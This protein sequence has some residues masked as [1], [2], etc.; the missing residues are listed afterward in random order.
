MFVNYTWT[1]LNVREL[2][3]NKFE[4]SWTIK[5]QGLMFVNNITE[6]VWMFVNNITKQVWMFVNN[7]TKQVWM[8]VKNI[9]EQVPMFVNNIPEQ[10]CVQ[11]LV[12]WHI[13]EA[14]QEPFKIN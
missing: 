6:Q 12:S 9:P 3:T 10:V 5:E 4:C 11:L 14:P 13:S 8:F 7:I 2:Y 1:S